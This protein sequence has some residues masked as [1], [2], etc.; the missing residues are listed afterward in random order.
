MSVSFLKRILKISD[1]ASYFKTLAGGPAGIR[2]HVR[3][4]SFPFRVGRRTTLETR[5]TRVTVLFSLEPYRINELIR[6]RIRKAGKNY[7]YPS[8][9]EGNKRKKSAYSLV[10]TAIKLQNV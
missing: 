9:Y 5:L 3:A 1:I 4:S 2:T 8:L 10:V 7:F 6:W